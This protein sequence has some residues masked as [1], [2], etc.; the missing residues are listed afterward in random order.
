MVKSEA[1]LYLAGRLRFMVRRRVEHT[2]LS[3][4]QEGKK[5]IFVR[6]SDIEFIVPDRQRR[7][8]CIEVRRGGFDK[9]LTYQTKGG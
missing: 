7:D 2:I 3:E 6:Y 4:E 9:V 8:A 1:M 5:D